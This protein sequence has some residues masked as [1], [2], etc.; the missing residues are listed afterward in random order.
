MGEAEK[1]LEFPA[2]EAGA[3]DQGWGSPLLPDALVI[4]AQCTKIEEHVFKRWKQRKKKLIFRVVHPVEY[5]FFRGEKDKKRPRPVLLEFWVREELHWKKP[6]MTA[7]LRKVLY[8]AQDGRPSP[9][10]TRITP[11]MFKNKL[12]RCKVKTVD[13]AF[14][15]SEVGELLGPA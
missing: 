5:S 1:V 8:A 15:Y 13:G 9:R 4:E 12:F 10:I 11:Q 6:P 14:P 2:T 7:K 3:I